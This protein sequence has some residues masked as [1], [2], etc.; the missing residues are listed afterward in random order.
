[1]P[2]KGVLT[3]PIQIDDWLYE[4]LHDFTTLPGFAQKVWVEYRES[5]LPYD[6]V[7][8]GREIKADP[9]TRPPEIQLPQVNWGRVGKS[10]L[11]VAGAVAKSGDVLPF[12]KRRH[13]H[14]R[15]KIIIC[16]T[17]WITCLLGR[18]ID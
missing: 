7:I 13:D 9:E 8:L 4:E 1:M 11:A 12:A 3:E 2:E 17:E 14:R 6:Q 15:S 16:V 18:L 10:A 5:G